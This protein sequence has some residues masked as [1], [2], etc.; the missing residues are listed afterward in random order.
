MPDRSARHH[1]GLAIVL[2]LVL[3]A[4]GGPASQATTGPSD[5]PVGVASPTP[6]PGSPGVPRNLA[7]RATLTASSSLRGEGP[8]RAADGDRA[9]S[10]SSG[11]NPP[12]WLRL[13][14]GAAATLTEVRLTVAQDPA[15]PT[16]HRVLAGATPSDLAEVHAFAGTT[17]DGDRLLYKLPAPLAGVRYVEVQTTMSPS[18]VAWREVA[19]LGY[20]EGVAP[21]SPP[22][23]EVADTIYV[24]GRILTME[25]DRPTAEAIAVR[26]D[27]ILA[28]GTGGEVLDHRGPGTRVVDLGGRTMTP[29]FVD[30]HAHRIGDRWHFGDASAEQMIDKALA[31]GW[32]SLHELFVTDQRLEELAAIARAD[33]LPI[34]VSLYL[35][36]NFHGDPSTWWQAY[37]PLQQLGPYLQIAGLKITLDQE[38]GE[39]VFLDGDRLRAMVLDAHRRGWQVAIHS[40]SPRANGLAL[41]AFSAALA[42]EGNAVARHRLE[43]LGVMTDDQVRRLADLGIIGSVQVV[44]ASSWVDDESF[45]RM[46]PASLREKSARWRDLLDAGAVLIA[47]TDDPWCCT[48]WRHGFAGPSIDA[49]I[50]RALHGAVTRA[51]LDGRPGEP[52]QVAQALTAAEALEMLTILGAYAAHQEDVI[53]SLR[54]GKYADLVVLS[55]DPLATPADRLL[56]LDVVMTVVGGAVRHCAPGSPSVCTAPGG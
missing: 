7:L 13:D 1:R 49:S 46:I 16:V 3:A 23:A 50:A 27:R 6:A 5:G 9:T 15:G 20:R 22:P 47:N 54:A 4:C 26:G 14:L 18:W 17:A 42:G 34:R 12:A 30:S 24:G 21:T 55:G 38:W 48:D 28:V 36:M 52:W 10:W 33:A 2:V 35:T 40:F 56:E 32:T 29:G 8:E 41:D 44:G 11:A 43:H 37:Q 31:Q 25:A 51:R 19:V 53:G 45:G 39:T